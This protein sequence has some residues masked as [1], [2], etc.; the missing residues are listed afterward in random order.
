[1]PHRPSAEAEA[2]AAGQHGDP[3]AFLGMHK[4]SIGLY[5]RA[6][7]P[8]AEAAAVLDSASGKI[9][10]RCERIHPAGLFVASMPERREPFRYRLRVTRGG[11]VHEFEDIYR[12]AP[13]LGD[14]D[15]HL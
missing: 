8:D 2:I 11:H 6:F 5:V 3:F 4:A 12:F 9:A 15:V 13:V 1:M 10:A 7:L 14:L